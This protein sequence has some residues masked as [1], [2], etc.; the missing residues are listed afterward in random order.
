[1]PSETA[2]A[3]RARLARQQEQYPELGVAALDEVFGVDRAL[4][5]KG[6]QPTTVGRAVETTYMEEGADTFYGGPI[7]QTPQNPRVDVDL[8]R[9][10]G[11]QFAS[12]TDV[13]QLPNAPSAYGPMD[14]INRAATSAPIAAS[15]ALFSR[16]PGQDRDVPLG[17]IDALFEHTDR[18]SGA[19]RG[20]LSG[21]NMQVDLGGAYQGFINPRE[22]VGEDVWGVRSLPEGSTRRMLAGL[23]AEILLDPLNIGAGG[24]I[25]ADVLGRAARG[26]LGDAVVDGIDTGFRTADELPAAKVLDPLVAEKPA[27][28]DWARPIRE[29]DEVAASR[30]DAAQAYAQTAARNDQPIYGPI[31]DAFEAANDIV[32]TDPVGWVRKYGAPKIPGINELSDWDRPGLK[33]QRR[34][35]E[36]HIANR[37]LNAAL[38]TE[39]APMRSGVIRRIDDVFGRG[40]SEGSPV[41]LN[42]R[43]DV[44]TLHSV[45]VNGNQIPYPGSGTVFD[46]LQR[47][48]AYTATPEM[49]AVAKQW[50][51]VD[52]LFRQKVVD[53]F[54]VDIER[55]VPARGGVY[56]RSV[57]NS[58]YAQAR[59]NVRHTDPANISRGEADDRVWE[60]AFERWAEGQANTAIKSE[61]A[62]VPEVNLRL[63]GDDAD[64]IKAGAARDMVLRHGLDTKTVTEVKEAVRPKLVQKRK[65][66]I[67]QIKNVQARIRKAE[68]SMRRDVAV[69]R[70]LD[71]QVR[72]TVRRIERIDD[73]AANLANRSKAMDVADATETLRTAHQMLR[74]SITELRQASIAAPTARQADQVVGR[75][76][77]K[78][79]ELQEEADRIINELTEVFEPGAVTASP[80]RGDTDAMTR[81]V[82]QS[83]DAA[84]RA[85]E[86]ARLVEEQ[87]TA[88]ITRAKAASQDVEVARQLTREAESG[89][90]S[91]WKLEDKLSSADTAI[92]ELQRRADAIE[93]AS[94]RARGSAD[95]TEQGVASIKSDLAALRDEYAI[96]AKD[97]DAVNLVGWES[98]ERM[99]GRYLPAEEARQANKMLQEPGYHASLEF[100]E[101]LRGQVLTGDA[102]PMSFIQGAFLLLRDTPATVRAVASSVAE[103]VKTGDFWLPYRRTT[104]ERYLAE[105]TDDVAEYAF[106]SGRM[107]G[108]VLPEEV[109]RT[110]L[111]GKFIPNFD[112]ANAAMFN[113][114]L[115]QNIN[116]F[117]GIR[118]D[119]IEYGYTRSEAAAA[120]VD[121]VNKSSPLS[122]TE[123]LGQS[124]A[125]SRAQRILPTSMAFIRQ[126]WALQG[127]A[128]AAMR[129]YATPGAQVSPRER[130]ALRL[131]SRMVGKTIAIGV[132][133]SAINA[134]AR[135]DSVTDA[136][137]NALDPGSR[138]FGAINVG[139]FSI[140]IANVFRA[141]V[142]LTAN[143][144][145]HGLNN[146]P[147]VETG[148]PKARDSV[149]DYITARVAPSVDA[150]YSSYKELA[151]AP[152]ER[153]YQGDNDALR[154]ASAAAIGG[155]ASLP[156]PAQG[157]IEEGMRQ[158]KEGVFDP[159][160]FLAVGAAEVGGAGLIPEEPRRTLDVRSRQSYGV[161]F[162]ELSWREQDKVLLENPALADKTSRDRRDESLK[163]LDGTGLLEIPEQA[164]SIV[165]GAFGVDGTY[166][167]ARDQ[168]VAEIASI[169]AQSGAPDPTQ[170]ARNE[171]Q[172]S[173]EAQMYS[174]IQQSMKNEWA[175][176]HIDTPY[177]VDALN[178]GHL[179]SNMFTRDL[180]SITE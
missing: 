78:A 80:R 14:I 100:M 135:G 19:A 11:G 101:N 15:Q 142:S 21:D 117:K 96:I 155:Q 105:N 16:L 131:W 88:S 64:A 106:Y 162:D 150:I 43:V 47:P 124:A 179:S 158:Q 34:L 103:S 4:R 29:L 67:A 82:T 91:A 148:E 127:E 113:V 110:G 44:D 76:S 75:L 99:P 102:G 132:A 151:S 36:T 97:Y 56:V 9:Y 48:F 24:Q 20:L 71:S 79:D 95:L 60:S 180:L 140:P 128:I 31:V 107:P 166:E 13:E 170:L 65:D 156:I 42:N 32:T 58:A 5:S 8:S 84:Q 35:L 40:A 90:E 136:V 168:W 57:D 163:R 167:E 77:K 161:A 152:F 33:M 144:V 147:G 7:R 3:R 73:V 141:P 92:N 27:I 18:L 45:T 28:F 125:T 171:W 109:A 146:I 130:M 139:D 83:Q 2:A 69:S 122:M 62:F 63:L 153:Q 81:L 114:I 116:A 134:E 120:A 26:R 70:A 94:I 112:Y 50:D 55:F 123:R 54:G 17:G 115:R 176:N 74:E 23:G 10:G 145:R 157:A 25:G 86:Q 22:T 12:L 149:I 41:L 61:Q 172:K 87:M 98:V 143:A 177:L 121:L 160:M 133:S 6:A 93:R 154:F 173:P 1:M 129:K 39:Q 175:L 51:Q 138:A 137:A 72:A 174:E 108:G 53:G 119:L 52:E 37:A 169:Y 159:K 89:V 46:Y 49:Q 165:S 30:S 104:M 178:T 126:P 118:D 68:E 59:A 111:L 66:M 38:R 164:W 85:L